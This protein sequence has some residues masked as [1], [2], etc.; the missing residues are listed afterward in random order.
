MLYASQIHGGIPMLNFKLDTFLTLCELRNYTKTAEHL[1]MTQPAVTQHIQYLEKYYNAKLFYYDERKR[2]HLTDYGKLLRAYAQ[3]VKAD[4]EILR[5]RLAS[6]AEYVDEYKIGSLTGTGEILVPKAAA[7]YL[8]QYPSKKISIYL[9]ESDDLLIQLKNGRVYA[10]II[11]T[12]CS[13][14]EYSVHELFESETI[15]VCAPEHPLAGKTVDFEELNQ[16]RLIFMS[17]NSKSLYNLRALLHRYNQD[18]NKFSSYIEVGTINT[19]HNMVKENAGISFVYQ[20]VVQKN[21]DRG[22]L[23]QIHI[24]NYFV[25]T[26]IN[27]VWMKNSFFERENQEFLKVPREYLKYYLKSKT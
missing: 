15:C 18:I 22:A 9:G 1:H 26:H 4:S 5:S 11:D 3:T 14:E 16:Y 12:Y 13:P 17:E 7:R 23:K 20:F 21:L 6:P 27:F 24:K 2:L 25:N 10:C 8:E 19:I